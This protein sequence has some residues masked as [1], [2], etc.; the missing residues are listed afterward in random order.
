[1]RVAP[2]VRPY[3]VDPLMVGGRLCGQVP[4]WLGRNTLTG[5]RIAVIPQ[6]WP[7]RRGYV[8]GIWVD[9][10]VIEDPSD[11]LPSVMSA[12]RRICPPHFGHSKGNTSYMQAI[13]TAHR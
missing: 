4:I 1:M 11:L 9:P 12:I 7:T 6:R 3:L 8:W 5:M 2:A 10:D 13:S